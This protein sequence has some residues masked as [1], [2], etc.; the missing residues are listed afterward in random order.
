MSC[1][2]ELRQQRQ[3]EMEEDPHKLVVNKSQRLFLGLL[4]LFLVDIIW[5]S[6]SELTKYIYQEAAFDKPFFT[7][8]IKTSMFTLYLL[9]LCFWPP[10]K[11]QCNKPTTYMFIDPNVEDDNFYSEG[12]TSLSDPT[13]VPVKSDRS[14]GTESDDSSVRSVRFS[15]FA[16]VRHM[17]ENDATEALLA[18][19]SYQA[20]V[21]AGERAK[22][23]ANKFSIQ[24]VVKIALMF[25]FLWFIGTYTYQMSLSQTEAGIVT[26]LS[27]TSSVFTLFLAAFFPSNNGDK[28]SL[29][30][31]VAV[32]ISIL[33]LV[34]VGISDL[35]V[36]A[37]RVPSGIILA[38]VS[39]FFYAVYIVFLR[40]KIDHEDK[41]DIPMFFGFV[42]L[43]NLLLFWPLFFI[44][45]YGQ[46]EEF[47][48]P[49]PHQWAFLVINGLVG[50]V[51]SKVLWLW[52]CFLTSSLIAS[53]AISLTVPISMIIDVVLKKVEYPCIF[54]LGSIPMILG[55]FLTVSLLSHFD[56][57][58]PVLDLFCRKS[59][60]LRIPDLEAEQTESL[61]GINSEH[62]A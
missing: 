16:E 55:S 45:H 17:S 24:K 42:G 58:D 2:V 22:R 5:V 4:V 27:S 18:R 59:R 43:F 52:G 54:Y 3:Q 37:S 8:Y 38:L 47:Q 21:R 40:K 28:F 19:L 46:W 13:F 25:C 61:I 57:W 51:F 15:K 20:S 6:S 30:K 14:S 10:W 44:L 26:V 41:M 48:W 62:E 11:D 39:A 9:G 36:E 31:L 23:Q 50:T 56:N 1:S 35:A 32:T 34:L 33:G 7:T 29:T 60:S 49:T 53:L 12:S